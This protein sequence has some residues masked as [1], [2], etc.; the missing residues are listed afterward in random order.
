MIILLI[1]W[2]DQAKWL[3]QQAWWMDGRKYPVLEFLTNLRFASCQMLF[4]NWRGYKGGSISRWPGMRINSPRNTA[5]SPA[6]F[7]TQGGGG[8][9]IVMGRWRG[10]FYTSYHYFYA[11]VNTPNCPVRET[12]LVL[13]TTKRN[14]TGNKSISL[15]ENSPHAKYLV[16]KLLLPGFQTVIALLFGFLNSHSHTV[17]HFSVFSKYHNLQTPYGGSGEL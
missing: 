17:P 4:V 8:E 3:D 11:N 6:G 10:I 15:I 16:L 2:E 5:G 13:Y 14:A 9:G 12:V 7:V 1:A